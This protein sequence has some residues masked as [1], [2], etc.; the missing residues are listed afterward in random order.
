MS[1]VDIKKLFIS[2]LVLLSIPLLALA[3]D[4]ESDAEA[5]AKERVREDFSRCFTTRL[6]SSTRKQNTCRNPSSADPVT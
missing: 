2:T 6:L 3:Q 4:D 1:I 5:E